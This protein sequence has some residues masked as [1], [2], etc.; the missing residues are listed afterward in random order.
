MAGNGQWVNPP[1][2]ARRASNKIVQLLSARAHGLLMP[3]TV[4]TNN[5]RYAVRVLPPGASRGI[6]KPIGESGSITAD[7]M[8]PAS[9]FTS[10][11]ILADP[12]S[13]RVAPGCFQRFIPAQLELRT[14]VFG[15]RAISVA[16][17]P[18][19]KAS[20]PD[21]TCQDLEAAD[22]AA[23]ADFPGHESK[24]VALVSELGLRYAAVDS[25]VSKGRCYFIEVNPNG[26][27]RWLPP[28]LQIPLDRE[29]RQL[30]LG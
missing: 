18:R 14:Y 30:V 6:S 15:S 17:R 5:P 1:G 3:R 7:W 20:T 23:T 8:A 10:D 19:G 25:L 26:G 12:A 22:F 4:I 27:W 13:V 11:E 16:I 9:F 21:V 24:L 28:G 29:F 2:S